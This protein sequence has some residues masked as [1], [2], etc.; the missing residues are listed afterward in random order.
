MKVSKLDQVFNLFDTNGR[1]SDVINAYNIYTNI[2]EQVYEES[3]SSVWRRYPN[4][5]TQ[6][7]FYEL[8]IE[9]SPEIFKQHPK[10]DNFVK[11]MENPK[12]KMAFDKGDI[13]YL[14]QTNGLKQLYAD[15]DNAIEGR[16]RHYSSNLVK[17]GLADEHRQ[18]SP[19][20]KSWIHGKKLRRSRFE[21]LLPID[22]TNLIFLRQLL[23][24]RVYAKDGEK[25]Y[26]PM[27]MAMYILL[28]YQRVSEDLFITMIQMLNPYLPIE[29]S[30]FVEE[31][32]GGHAQKLEREYV[33][34]STDALDKINNEPIPMSKEVFASHFS[35]GKSEKTIK[36]YREFYENLVR[37]N[38]EGT[39]EN[40]EKL[41]ELFSDT[42]KKSM[43]NKA[44]GFGRNVF[45]FDTRDRTNVSKFMELNEDVDI[46]TN[47][48][49]N[50][51]LFL[52]FQASKRHD[53]VREYG[54]VTRRVMKVT[55]IISFKNGVVELAQRDLWQKFFSKINLENMVFGESTNEA[56]ES[57][58][59][60]M[61]SPFLNHLTLEEILE[62]EDEKVEQA[63]VEIKDE[64]N[65]ASEEEI[66]ETIFNQTSEAFIQHIE[67]NYPKEKILE[68][69]QLFS[70]RS[71]DLKIQKM[72]AENTD[73]PTIF[74]YIV[75]IAWYHI[76]SKKFDLFSSFNLSMSA[77]F[78]P[79]T[80]A[81][82]GAGDI[83]IDYDD[84]ILML[85]VTLMN[86]HA[87]KRGE[88]EPV[89]RH[90]TNLTIESAPK[91]VTTLFIADDLD[92]NTINIW[93][94]VAT[95]PLQSSRESDKFAD[96]V[97]IMPVKNE[98]LAKMIQN[99][100]NE[101][102]LLESIKESFDKLSTDFNMGWRDEI[103]KFI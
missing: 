11:A 38:R 75:G 62:Y 98:E 59:K 79:E 22:E 67:T 49:L 27:L 58:E 93:R 20:G 88:W 31:F 23:K 43:I 18:I 8:A 85:E 78:E 82:G 76:S 81:G 89:L 80:H 36:I 65:L 3:E 77:D 66:R 28:N 86:K 1:R 46:L 32:L 96:T 64:L 83:V 53:G 56:Y 95:V 102:E 63:I 70:D 90:A 44:F 103:I 35:S 94:A 101:T 9:K 14:K 91:K 21:N 47:E 68:I 41:V 87:Q 17:I 5:S 73:V 4:E 2:L 92:E 51:K 16:A 61:T 24:L 55:G 74:E 57:Y 100:K 42:Q 84:H 39:T 25:Y 12:I 26:S 13:S 7:R 10:Y 54:D 97:T 45:T 30:S 34:F 29:P 50:T 40:L 37:F 48:D 60:E 6:F 69:L 72:V 52:Q 15:L 19:V 99:R 33:P 71:N